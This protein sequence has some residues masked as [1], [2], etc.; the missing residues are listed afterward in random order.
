M[1]ESIH[2][3]QTDP[4]AAGGGGLWE[5]EAAELMIGAQTQS[6]LERAMMQPNPANCC[7]KK[8]PGSAVI[9]SVCAF[10][11]EKVNVNMCVKVCVC[12][13]RLASSGLAVVFHNG[14]EAGG[15]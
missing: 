5:N 6:L 1:L 8:K 14:T 9:F 4:W 15:R 2:R 11:R 7:C 10:Q 13:S 12:A 3:R